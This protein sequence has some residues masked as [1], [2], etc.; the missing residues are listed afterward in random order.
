MVAPHNTGIAA[1]AFV[2][3]PGSGSC[4]A[5]GTVYK[6]FSR[7][8]GAAAIVAA[9]YGPP[10]AVMQ[11]QH[12]RLSSSMDAAFLRKMAAIEDSL[13]ESAGVEID[14]SEVRR[15][16]REVP[17]L[18]AG[19][20]A[21]G[22]ASARPASMR[23]SA[24]PAR[25]RSPDGGQRKR[26]RSQPSEENGEAVAPP[27]G[28]GVQDDIHRR[29]RRRGRARPSGN[30][31]LGA[32]AERGACGSEGRRRAAED[33]RSGAPLLAKRPFLLSAES[34]RRL[35]DQRNR[36]LQEN[37]ALLQRLQAYQL[38]ESVLR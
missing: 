22:G 15:A 37:Q 31:R 5:A 14:G 25:D 32:D 20:R 30:R 35:L 24:L 16:R 28:Q 36:L 13:A 29:G 38:N 4:S 23:T 3:I 9:R 10:Q 6:D 12:R 17:D 7:V 19:A 34:L 21:G 26:L 27:Q 1:R 18:R 33:G 8:C 11:A 2:R